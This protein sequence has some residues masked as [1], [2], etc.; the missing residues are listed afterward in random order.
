[1]GSMRERWKKHYGKIIVISVLS[2][3]FS[4]GI[5]AFFFGKVIYSNMTHSDTKGLYIRTLDQH[6]SYG[7]HVILSGAYAPRPQLKLLK[8]VMG[9]PGDRFT[10]TGDTLWIRGIPYPLMDD[11]RIPHLKLGDYI[12]PEGTV[13]CLN[14]APDSFDSR[15]LGPLPI[16]KVENRVALVFSY[17]EIGSFLDVIFPGRS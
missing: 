17:E 11:P 7:D 10:V 1:M 6:L 15:Y 5:Y 4:L 16:D 2:L 13:M 3:F 9:F 14:P 8:R 12:V